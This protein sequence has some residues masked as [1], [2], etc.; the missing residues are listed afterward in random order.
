MAAPDT[1]PSVTLQKKKTFLKPA[2]GIPLSPQQ[3]KSSSVS[4]SSLLHSLILLQNS[5]N[6]S[7]TA[8]KIPTSP[9]KRPAPQAKEYPLQKEARNKGGSEEKEEEEEGKAKQ[10]M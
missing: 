4:P 5:Q 6:I 3:R 1:F 2:T 10:S 7:K 9:L 8:T